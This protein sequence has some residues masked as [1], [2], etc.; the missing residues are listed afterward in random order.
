MSDVIPSAL[1]SVD[2][3]PLQRPQV[4][5]D[6]PNISAVI[7]APVLAK[8]RT[9][10]SFPAPNAATAMENP[11]QEVT[12]LERRASGPVKR[13]VSRACDHCH[14]MRTRCN[15]QAPCSR[16]VGT[17]QLRLASPIPLT[18]PQNSSMCASTTEKRRGGERSVPLSPAAAQFRLLS[19]E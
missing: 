5:H 18:L 9:N 7:A 15:G 11:T 2:S 12:K 16:C 6:R 17:L 3:G 1:Y 13:R 8:K 19:R 10:S 4:S 14:R